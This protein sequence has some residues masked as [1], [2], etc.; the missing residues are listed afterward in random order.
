MD[1]NE[2]EQLQKWFVNNDLISPTKTHTLHDLEQ[3]WQEHQIDSLTLIREQRE[4][5]WKHV[6]ENVD[7]MNKFID[8]K[9]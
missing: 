6:M 4:K 7:L 8:L 2:D 9:F 1:S 3:L 5:E